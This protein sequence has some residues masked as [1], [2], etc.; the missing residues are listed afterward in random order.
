M[1]WSSTTYIKTE[2]N[3]QNQYNVAQMVQV[4]F[5]TLGSQKQ[6]NKKQNTNKNKRIAVSFSFIRFIKINS[7]SDSGNRYVWR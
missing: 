1:C 5:L 6:T 7:L 2:K 3:E 4:Y